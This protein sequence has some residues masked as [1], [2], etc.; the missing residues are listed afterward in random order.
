M[1]A[2]HYEKIGQFIDKHSRTIIISLF[3]SVIMMWAYYY[4]NRYFLM[5]TENKAQEPHQPLFL[6]YSLLVIAVLLLLG[7]KWAAKRTEL[8]WQHFSRY[9]MLASKTSFGMFLVQ[10]FPLYVVK[11]IVPL[12]DEMKWLYVLLLPASILFVYLSAMIM[13]YWLNDTA[14]VSYVVGKKS[15]WINTTKT[16][17]ARSDL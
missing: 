9:V 8:K 11:Q 13:S 2:C 10:P 3:F 5:L 12:F 1:V 17:Q 16:V 4:Y 15:T 14:I 7:R 6:P